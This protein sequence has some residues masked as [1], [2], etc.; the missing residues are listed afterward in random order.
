MG[1]SHNVFEKMEREKDRKERLKK[2][3]EWQKEKVKKQRKLE[4]M[5]ARIKVAEKK[6]RAAGAGGKGF[7]GLVRNIKCP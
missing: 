5:R 7:D 6:D 4:E 1:I 2:Y 3:E